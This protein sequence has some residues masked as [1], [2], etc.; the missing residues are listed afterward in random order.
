MVWCGAAAPAVNDE[1]VLGLKNNL[2][3]EYPY[4]WLLKI[5]NVAG[6]AG[7]DN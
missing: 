2:L 7:K 6:T 5:T 1:V 3:N 4:G